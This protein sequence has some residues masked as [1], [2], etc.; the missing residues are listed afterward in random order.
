MSHDHHNFV[1]KINLN[2]NNLNIFSQIVVINY[3][4]WMQNQSRI[5][6]N[7]F[8][9]NAKII[10]CV[11]RD[12]RTRSTAPHVRY[13]YIPSSG[14]FSLDWKRSRWNIE[15][16]RSSDKAGCAI[17]LGSARWKVN[18]STVYSHWQISKG[19]HCRNAFRLMGADNNSLIGKSSEKTAS[20]V[21]VLYS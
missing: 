6:P 8:P 15:T 4:A 19:F 9:T 10:S 1:N 12:P 5:L 13:I 11:P 16:G 21:Y 20:F 14:V 18:I 3:L 2:S 7:W 17:G